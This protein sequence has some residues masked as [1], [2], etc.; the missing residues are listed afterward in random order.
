MALRPQ[1]ALW[2]SL[3]VCYFGAGSTKASAADVSEIVQRA[4]AALNSDWAA[5]PEYACI[6]R[7]EVRHGDAVTSKLG[8][9]RSRI[10]QRL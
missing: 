1:R 6:E 2:L 7:D 5:D 10:K 9:R 3:V 4:T 8:H